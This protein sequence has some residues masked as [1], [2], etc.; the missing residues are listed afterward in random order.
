ML[1]KINNLVLQILMSFWLMQSVVN[2]KLQLSHTYLWAPYNQYL[3]RFFWKMLDQ[4]FFV[5]YLF[6]LIYMLEDVK[7]TEVCKEL[8][9]CSN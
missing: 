6:Y 7:F 5:L 3:A 1:P 2:I 8:A 4:T 9:H